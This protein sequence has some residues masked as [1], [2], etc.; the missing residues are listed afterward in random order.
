[1]R[2]TSSP[3]PD[4]F[5]PAFYRKFWPVVGGAVMAFVN[6]FHQGT[7]DF[8]RINQAHVV[9]L[10]KKVDVTTADGCRPVSLQNYAS[11]L[12]AKI[13]TTRLQG[14][15]TSLISDLQTG[16]VKRRSIT[17][18][19]LFAS[20]L[21]Q[22]WLRGTVAGL[23]VDH[24]SHGAHSGAAQWCAGAVDP[25]PRGL[26]QGDPLS[27][28]LFIIVADLLHRMVTNVSTP[29]V[30]RHLL[31]DDLE[32]LVIQYADDTLVQVR[33]LKVVLDDFAAVTGLGINFTKSTFIPINVEDVHTASMA[34][35][36]GCSVGGGGSPRPILG[37]PFPTPKSPPASSTTW[38]S[39]EHC[40][41]GWRVH[42]LTRGGVSH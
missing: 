9:L 34:A 22:C 23:D 10:P 19:F 42:T 12:A 32:C 24:P 6:A 30:L 7:A 5:G 41:L 40:I 17:D 35:I 1:M 25:L 38:L 3:G 31:V 36:L 18:N 21:L 28:Y 8:G 16:F 2:T 14:V 4:G 26:R 33:R 20:E 27:P 39:R 29:T 13:L 11:K 15:V 37:S